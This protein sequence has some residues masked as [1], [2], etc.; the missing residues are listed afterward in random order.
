MLL[1]SLRAAEGSYLE[2][3]DVTLNISDGDL[4]SGS[5]ANGF[6]GN[7]NTTF[8]TSGVNK[9]NVDLK[10][11][12][13][14]VEKVT[15]GINADSGNKGTVTLYGPGNAFIKQIN[16]HTG[17]DLTVTLDSPQTVARVQVERASAKAGFSFITIGEGDVS[18]HPY[19]YV[20]AVDV[21]TRTVGFSK[22]YTGRPWTVGR[23]CIGPA[24]TRAADAVKKYLN[25]DASLNVI[26]LTDDDS[27]TATPGNTVTPKISFPGT[28]DNGQ[29]PD[30]ALPDGTSIQTEFKAENTA[31]SD[32]MVSNVVTPSPSC[33]SGP[34]E[35]GVITAVDTATVD[36][37]QF[38]SSPNG[39][40]SG[41]FGGDPES[42]FDGTTTTRCQSA[43]ITTS[44]RESQ[45]I[46]EQVLQ[47]QRLLQSFLV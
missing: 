38:I 47:S 5:I 46:F 4:S 28:L 16:N 29:A 41:A 23:T 44:L 14:N 13:E 2:Q 24:V 32:E 31:G 19:G 7:T 9:I 43:G 37:S 1:K 6:D 34:I 18:N 21:A 20:A 15:V 35:T 27:Y 3:S 26:G 42:A 11:P 39:F 40:D 8:E 17:G 30:S 36:Y 25:L 10:S 33:V 12:V 45:L 22:E